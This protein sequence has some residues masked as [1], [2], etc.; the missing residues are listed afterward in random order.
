VTLRPVLLRTHFAAT[1]IQGAKEDEPA[2]LRSKIPQQ[3]VRWRW[4]AESWRHRLALS[5][6]V[7]CCRY[8]PR[9]QAVNQVKSLGGFETHLSI[10]FYYDV[11][12]STKYYSLR[13][14]TRFNLMAFSNF[15]VRIPS[16]CQSTVPCTI[17][18]PQSTSKRRPRG[19]IDRAATQQS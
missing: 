5:L 13:H 17:L 1:G 19:I 10:G 18:S 9:T 14:L 12:T 15:T 4:K 6:L 8:I 11:L 16:K 3:C 7:V 2:G